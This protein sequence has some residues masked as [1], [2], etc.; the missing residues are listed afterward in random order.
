VI[1][2]RKMSEDILSAFV[3]ST[4]TLEPV[5]DTGSNSLRS[6]VPTPLPI[7]SLDYLDYQR[8]FT[9][10]CSAHMWSRSKGKAQTDT[11]VFG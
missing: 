2:N 7:P 10:M 3:G 5:L 11:C 1:F 8:G 9:I 6:A 4:Y